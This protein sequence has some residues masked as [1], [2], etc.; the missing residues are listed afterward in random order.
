MHWVLATTPE[1]VKIPVNL[2]AIPTMMR[3][4]D[5]TVL[6]LG[7]VGVLPHPDPTKPLIVEYART[8]VRETPEQLLALPEVSRIVQQAA[9]RQAIV[10]D[11]TRHA[12]KANPAAPAPAP[13]RDTGAGRAQPGTAPAVPEGCTEEDA[14]VADVPVT[15]KP[16]VPLLNGAHAEEPPPAR[17]RMKDA[18]AARARKGT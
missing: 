8:L 4:G 9:A 7:G 10:A 13:E 18:R 12:A 2:A 17:N 11:A 5:A 14:Y 1:G 3:L 6:F 15:R 16:G